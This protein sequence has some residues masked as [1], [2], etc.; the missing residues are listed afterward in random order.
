MYHYDTIV[1]NVMFRDGND[2]MNTIKE[3]NY[4]TTYLDISLAAVK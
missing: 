3:A 4:L 1:F 2:A